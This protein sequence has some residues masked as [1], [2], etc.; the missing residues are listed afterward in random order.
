MNRA[1]LAIGVLVGLSLALAATSQENEASAAPDATGDGSV[2]ARTAIDAAALVGELHHRLLE[3]IALGTHQVLDRHP[4]VG[5]VH[6]AEVLVGSHVL[7]GADLDA[8]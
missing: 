1:A 8:R 4:H 7:D 5:E 6:L 2:P 3:R